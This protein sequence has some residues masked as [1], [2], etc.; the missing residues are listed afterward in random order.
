MAN[1]NIYLKKGRVAVLLPGNRLNQFEADGDLEAIDGASSDLITI[2]RTEDTT[3]YIADIGYDQILDADNNT[4]ASTRDAVKD[5]LN[6]DVF[7]HEF[8]NPRGVSL[9]VKNTTS[10]TLTKGTPVHATGVTGNVADVI[11]ARADSVLAMPATYVLNE[12]IAASENGE[13]LLIGEIT[14]IDTSAF[15]AGDVIYVAPTGGFTK[16]RPTGTNLVQN[17]GV[18]TKSNANKGSGVVLGSGRTND[19]PNLPQDHIW[20]GDANAL[21]VARPRDVIPLANISGRYMWSS[22]DD[23]ERVYTGS[24]VYGPHNWYSHSSEPVVSNLRD[25]SGSEV[26]DTTT[27]SIQGYKLLTFGIKNPYSK[28]PVRIDYSFRIYYSSTAPDTD[29]PFGFS[30]WTG[31]ANATGSASGVTLTYRGESVDHGMVAP[32]VG[33]TTAHHHGSFTTASDINDDYLL[34]LAEHRASTGLNNTTYMVANY[35]VYIAD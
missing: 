15:S 22:V 10:G 32:Q 25:Y 7:N 35:S 4:Y 14:D 28:R 31:N 17:L 34:V 9:R 23:G 5:K 21:A 3:N 2:R 29:T 20:V 18:V 6:E 11:A 33:G 27:T 19:V 13:A 16:D 12:D 8:V 24:T 1:V 30:L 26:V